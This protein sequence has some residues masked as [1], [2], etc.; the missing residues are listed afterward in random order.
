MIPFDVNSVDNLSTNLQDSLNNSLG[1]YYNSSGKR[2]NHSAILDNSSFINN[3]T[4]AFE[5]GN[6]NEMI[7]KSM[8]YNSQPI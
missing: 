4:V 7:N 8:F 6:L 2:I 1:G 5:P 3:N